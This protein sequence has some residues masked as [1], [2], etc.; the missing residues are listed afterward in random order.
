MVIAGL[1]SIVFGLWALH[2]RS[3]WMKKMGAVIAPLGLIVTLVG[4]LLLCVPG[5][6]SVSKF[7]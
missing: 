7:W 5:F 6:F 1:V 3:G 2:Y 4:V